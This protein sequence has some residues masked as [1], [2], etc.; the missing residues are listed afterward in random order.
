MRPRQLTFLVLCV[1]CGAPATS[2]RNIGGIL[3]PRCVAHALAA[4]QEDLRAIY[5]DRYAYDG[6]H[7]LDGRRVGYVEALGLYRMGAREQAE[8]VA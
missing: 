5:G 3:E 1:A 4:E 7:R 8:G 2:K 6:G